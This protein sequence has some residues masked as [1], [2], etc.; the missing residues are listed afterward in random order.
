M[1]NQFH[2]TP[3]FVQSVKD[4]IQK[5]IEEGKIQLKKP[6]EV[7]VEP[8]IVNK[9]IERPV[10]KCFTCPLTKQLMNDPV[11]ISSGNTYER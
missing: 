1:T 8:E 7:K 4:S 6:L 9:R 10:P 5:L 3:K 2:V 11:M